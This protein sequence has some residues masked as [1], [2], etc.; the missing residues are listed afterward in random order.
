MSS[1]GSVRIELLNKDNFDTWKIQMEAILV[2]SDAWAYVSG[3]KV[4]PEV[5]DKKDAEAVAAEKLWESYDRKAKSDIILAINPSELKQVKGCITS[6]DMWEKLQ[7]I[8]QSKGPARK[9][10]LL[11]Q[12][13]LHRMDDAGDVRDHLHKFFDIIDKLSEMEIEINE[14][15]LTIMLLYSLPPSFENFR[16]AIE[17]RDDLPKPEILRVKIVEE[18]DAR[19][20]ETRTVI[21]NAMIA[22][23]QG[24]RRVK[25]WSKNKGKANESGYKEFKYKCFRCHKQG[26]KAIYCPERNKEKANKAENVSL[27]VSVEDSVNK[28]AFVGGL[29]IHRSNWCLDSGATAHLCKYLEDFV[30]INDTTP[31]KLNLASSASTEITASGTVSILSEIDGRLTNV[32]VHDTS[33]VPDLRTSLLSVGKITDQGFKVIF[34]QKSAA[35]V[36]KERRTVLQADR[37]NGLYFLREGAVQCKSVSQEKVSVSRSIKT[38]NWHRK[39]GHLN[40]RDLQECDRKGTVRGMKLD[41]LP[42]NFKCEICIRGKMTR[43]PFPKRLEKSSEL[44]EIIYS[45]VW[46]PA[47]VE[48]NGGAKYFVTFID[49]F[50]G[51][52][53]IRL[54][55]KKSEVFNQFKDFKISVEN[56]T[57][58]KIKYLQSDN[59]KEY[60]NNSFDEFLRTNGIGRRLTVTHTPEQNGVAERRNRTLV[61]MARCLLIQSELPQSFWGEA[62]NTA[63][64]TRNRCP[65]RSI[66]GKTAFEKWTG[67][68]P[69][70][71]YFREFGSEVFTLNRDPTKNK[72]ESRSTKGIFIGYSEQSK[73]YRIWIPEERKIDITRDTIFTERPKIP[74]TGNLEIS[75]KFFD[76][77][78]TNQETI[79]NES[80]EEN[81]L[82]ENE[83]NVDSGN[84]DEMREED[85][86]AEPRPECHGHDQEEP[87]PAAMN[88]PRRGRGRP[89]KI[90]TG[91]RGRPR[92]QYQ[93]AD[94]VNIAEQVEEFGGLAEIPI[95]DA[96]KGPD[97]DEW[98]QAMATELKSIIKNDTWIFVD[99]PQSQPVI[100]SRIVLRNKYNADGTLDKRKARIVARGFSQRP[101]IDFDETFAPVARI[102]SIRMLTSIAAQYGMQIKQFDVTTAYLNGVLEEKIYMEVPNYT[103]D[104]LEKIILSEPKTSEIRKKALKLLEELQKGNKVCFMKKALYG[105][106]QAG[107]RWHFRLC[108]ELARFGIKQSDYDQCVFY[109]GRG[110]DIFLVAIY[111]DDIL[112]ISKDEKKIEQFEKF[113][114]KRFDI[115]SLGNV[116]YCLGIE[117]SR[118]E[119]EIKMSQKGYLKDILERFGMSNANSVTT[120]I[121]LGIK[122]KK[123]DR[124]DDRSKSS[125]S[126]SLPYRELLGSLMYL[127]VCTRPDIA[128]VV[129]YLSQYNSCY[130]STHWAA[131]KRVLRYLKG[132]QD[133]GLS[134]RNTEESLKGFVDADW[135]NCPNDR[136]SYSGF[137]FILGGN[138]ISWESRKQRTPALSSTE[139]E[140]MA[141]TEAAKEALYL[142]RFLIEIGFNEMGYVKLMSDSQGAQKL[143][144]NAVFHNRTKHIDVRHH[145]VRN[146]LKNEENFSIDHVSTE[147]MAADFLTKGLPRPKHKRC[148]ELLGMQNPEM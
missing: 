26:H 143:A 105:L 106:R 94:D 70:V 93:V 103:E 148:L 10:T 53:V 89:K 114:S 19:K 67:K 40:M 146:I 17:S 68:I 147:N 62:I 145:F 22:K 92:K 39:M 117:F 83:V 137:V 96:I 7:T 60:V 112:V 121:E 144:K 51:W 102:G 136:R 87:M 81:R 30:E 29:E 34:D 69:N 47:R 35:I 52:C 132:T 75:E 131:A 2:K 101:G 4:K 6:K 91:N 139:A 118:T 32:S 123:S 23:N 59:G 57:G 66:D 109:S 33:H 27:F 85:I 38:E 46:G 64:Y 135:A 80:Q 72:F 58:K 128:H 124:I 15:L 42:N 108:E 8:Y 14:D 12:L 16:C 44:L 113:L 115:K 45:D 61:E 125:E 3:E 73:A 78:I 77:P 63:N 25:N 54:I 140:Y 76:F 90:M 111:V 55:K 74:S 79:P 97:S 122:L 9:A 41:G 142:R 119:C 37:V 141:L 134:F 100:S 84:D 126:E 120:P 20:N 129:S 56:Q 21:P 36:D 24:E 86:N 48:S 11:K 130:D 116:K 50:S 95:H 82:D 5:P 88:E 31:R 99:R 104:T 43:S 107:R 49:D 1:F 65:S 127:A 71:K 13:T 28:K 138:P 133:V 18:Y 110:E 98:F